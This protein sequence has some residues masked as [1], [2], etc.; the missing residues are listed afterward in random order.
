MFTC[1]MHSV[2][3]K[4]RSSRISG[5]TGGMDDLLYM[6][7]PPIL[8]WHEQLRRL[9]PVRR[10][11]LTGLQILCAKLHK[12]NLRRN[13][14][15]PDFC[16]EKPEMSIGGC[17]A[18]TARVELLAVSLASQQWGVGINGSSGA[19]LMGSI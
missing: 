17:P 2:T 12:N 16:F 5:K 8:W 10:R 15:F 6:G 14:G 19:P 13:Q 9:D 3:I 18:W 1:A 11:D 7:I 4:G